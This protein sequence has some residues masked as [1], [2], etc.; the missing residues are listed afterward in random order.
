MLYMRETCAGAEFYDALE[1]LCVKF[2]GAV[3]LTVVMGEPELA[4]VR[5]QLGRRKMS[6][7]L[8]GARL[9][10]ESKP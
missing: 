5:E 9:T 7:A 6:A 10:V 8:D 2:G 1:L 4:A 3:V